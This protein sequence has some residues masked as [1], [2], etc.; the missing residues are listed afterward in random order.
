M[1]RIFSEYGE[2]YIGTGMRSHDIYHRSQVIPTQMP[3]YQGIHWKVSHFKDGAITMSD[4]ERNTYP[5]CVGCGY[6]CLKIMCIVGVLIHGRLEERCPFLKWSKKRVRYICKLV[7]TM[8][9]EGLESLN[10][11]AGCTSNLNSWRKEVKFRG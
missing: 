9:K 4:C 2:K 10:I 1:A 6:C 7:P 5:K 3:K 8:S 11:G